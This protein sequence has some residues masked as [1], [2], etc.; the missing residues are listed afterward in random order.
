MSYSV[1]DAGEDEMRSE[2]KALEQLNEDL[3]QASSLA[4]DC[5]TLCPEAEKLVDLAW[6]FTEN[7]IR[8]TTGAC[9]AHSGAGCQCCAHF[10]ELKQR[11]SSIQGRL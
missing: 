7:A 1:T 2:L 5:G 11:A 6:W 9:S 4:R 10:S 3:D 8:E